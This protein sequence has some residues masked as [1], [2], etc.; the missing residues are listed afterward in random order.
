[1]KRNRKIGALVATFL[2][3]GLAYAAFAHAAANVLEGPRSAI[4][5]RLVGTNSDALASRADQIAQLDGAGDFEQAERL[6]RDALSNSLLSA[7]AF[8]VLASIE[9]RRGHRERAAQLLDAAERLRPRE[10]GVNVMRLQIAAE[11]GDLDSFYK[12]LGRALKTNRK[13][14]DLLFPVAAAAIKEP[15]LEDGMGR[16]LDQSEPWVPHFVSHVIRK[17]PAAHS[18]LAEVLLGMDTLPG[19]GDFDSLYRQLVQSLENQGEWDLILRTLRKR[20]SS[21]VDFSLVFDAE[22]TDSDLVPLTWHLTKTG[23]IVAR[24]GPADQS[25]RS[26]LIVESRRPGI[27]AR[28][29]LDLEPGLFA[30]S[31]KSSWS[32]GGSSSAYWELFCLA[33]R[34]VRMVARIEI[35]PEEPESSTNFE[36]TSGCPFQ[37]I[38]MR[39]SGERAEFQVHNVSLESAKN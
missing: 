34:S 7:R 16:F 32:A 23:E 30:L 29:L 39:T 36:V 6:A 25:G 26:K 38:A 37:V 2:S 33:E 18:Q 4:A 1:M 8:R 10:I 35:S 15:S 12:Y 22:N 31:A 14:W 17:D 21:P 3:V 13:S 19:G 11:D 20:S 28:K 27:A 9:E 24:L 5:I